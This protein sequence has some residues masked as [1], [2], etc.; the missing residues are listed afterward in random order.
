M[1]V[2][3]VG[4]LDEQHRLDRQLLVRCC[5]ERRLVLLQ[6]TLVVQRDAEQGAAGNVMQGMAHALL[7]AAQG[8]GRPADFVNVLML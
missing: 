8:G 2:A 4:G 3:G 5:D 7:L 1:L 6:Q